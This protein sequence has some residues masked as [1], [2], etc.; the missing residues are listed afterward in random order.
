MTV[1]SFLDRASAEYRTAG[2]SEL[3]RDTRTVTFPTRGARVQ[4]TADADVI[5]PAATP[6]RKPGPAASAPRP[7]AAR[8]ASVASTSTRRIASSLCGLRGAVNVRS[9]LFFREE[10]KEPVD[11]DREEDDR[12]LD[13]HEEPGELLVLERREPP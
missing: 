3:D 4:R 7:A 5:S 8:S 1:R 2:V 12:L 13:G 11:E 10:A 9:A 6:Y